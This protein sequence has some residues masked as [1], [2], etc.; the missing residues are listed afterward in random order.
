M[1]LENLLDVHTRGSCRVWGETGFGG[2][3]RSSCASMHRDGC[4]HLR[5][6]ILFR[7]SRADSIAI[8]LHS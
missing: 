3:F 6:G 8:E 5:I 4:Y 2:G 7:C 1:T